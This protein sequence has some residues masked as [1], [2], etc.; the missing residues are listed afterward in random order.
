MSCLK[1]DF[2]R[3]KKFF[4]DND[5]DLMS[6]DEVAAWVYQDFVIR[7]RETKQFYKGPAEL[8]FGDLAIFAEN[9]IWCEDENQATVFHHLVAKTD[10]D[11][12]VIRMFLKWG[13]QACEGRETV[14]RPLG[15]PFAVVGPEDPILLSSECYAMDNLGVYL[16]R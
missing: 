15:A 10:W 2:K 16:K 8:H 1:S 11:V 6:D 9:D 7:D 3:S 13:T 14:L 4:I 12:S 5:Y